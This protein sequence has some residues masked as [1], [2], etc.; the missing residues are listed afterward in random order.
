MHCR[1]PDLRDF[2]LTSDI[3]MFRRFTILI[4]FTL[5]AV[6]LSKLFCA[7]AGQTALS[8]FVDV[9]GKPGSTTSVDA[10]GEPGSSF[11]LQSADDRRG[12]ALPEQGTEFHLAVE[13]R[14]HWRPLIAL[15][16]PV[17][18]LRFFACLAPPPAGRPLH[19]ISAFEHSPSSPRG[20]PARP[21]RLC[22]ILI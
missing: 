17:F 22:N 3:R 16:P 18:Q 5:M 13:R 15:F 4:G 1:V 14:V 9:T 10:T 6:A 21:I 11:F 8:S 7:P 12:Y 20:P 19:S 2:C